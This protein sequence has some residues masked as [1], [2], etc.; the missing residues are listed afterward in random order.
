MKI[1]LINNLYDPHILG[2]AER[3][4]QILA[5]ALTKNGDQAVVVSANPDRGTRITHIND[6]KV[7]YTSIKNLYS[8]F[9][10]KEGFNPLL[11]FW[12]MIDTYNPWMAEKI[13]RIIDTEAPDAIHTHNLAGFSI[14]IWP[15]VANRKLPLIHTLRDYYL[16]CPRS[17]MFQ[18]GKNCNTQCW[19]CRGYS[20]L[21]KRL[22]AHVDVVAGISSY[23]LTR[24]RSRG[25][26]KKTQTQEI[27]YN[28]YQKKYAVHSCH[29]GEGKPLRLGYL[30]QLKPAKGIELL[31]QALVDLPVKDYELRL[32]GKG[33][34]KFLYY[35][36]NQYP[37]KNI[38]FLDFVD[39]ETFF[40]GIDVL[41]VPSLWHE[42]LGRTILEAYAHGVP[43]ITSD[44]GGIPEI[45]DVGKTGFIFNPD[46]PDSLV[47]IIVKIKNNPDLLC[48]M[49]TDAK[50]KSRAFLPENSLSQYMKIYGDAI[51]SNEKGYPSGYP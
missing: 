43:V 40:P 15:A 4:V 13:G 49:G 28:A 20:W 11:P 32:G 45:V 24:H 23:I 47:S 29:A 8:F 39:P 42:P 17:T 6:V 27:I 33:P 5:E 37:I 14:S 1:L 7:Y 35:L 16:L 30:G 34:E 9:K 36:K 50:K 31:L 46:Q 21:K 48:R 3:S 12:H 38:R 10:K 41:I 2:G 22:S 25:Y 51:R 19:Y 44:R 18:H 26:F